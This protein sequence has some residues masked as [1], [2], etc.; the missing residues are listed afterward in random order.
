MKIALCLLLLWFASAL[1]LSQ[2]PEAAPPTSASGGEK[3]ATTASGSM[4]SILPDLD[5]LQTVSE[6]AAANLGQLH[7]EKWKANSGAKSVAQADA[8]SVQRNLTSALPG[9]IGAVRSAP[10]DTNAAFKLY[11]NLNALYDVFGTLT[12]STRVF[13]QRAAYETLSQQLQLVGSVRRKLGE[14][15]EQLTASTQ[16]QLVQMRSQMKAQQQQL[17]AAQAETAEVRKELAVAQTPPPPKKAA[18]KKTVAKKPAATGS[19]SGAN[20]PGSNSSGQTGTG[21]TAPKS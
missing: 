12:E 8:D 13:G 18:K 6:Q 19:G 9:L 14:S 3:P 5:K 4:T 11:R 21:T 17:A 20:P 2:T 10:E 1:L 15:L 7:I 16:K